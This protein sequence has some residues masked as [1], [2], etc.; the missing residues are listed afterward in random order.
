M[1]VNWFVL[2]R[3]VHRDLGY[4]ACALT[5]VY[6]ISGIAVNHV[7]DWNPNQSTTTE[8][9]ALGPLAAGSL[10]D[11]ER[12]VVQKARLLP[13][14]VKGRHRSGPD[15]LRV[16]L[17]NGGEVK[18]DLPTGKGTITRIQPRRG[19]FELNVLHLNHLKGVWT[20]V[21]DGYAVSLL[22]LG[23]SGLFMVSGK[24]GFFGRGKWFVLAG[25]VVPIVFV[26][27]YHAT[28]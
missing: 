27:V 11:L 26:W 16:F 3:A 28:R 7:A 6:A 12:Q 23:V 10:D 8:D 1:S 17:D 19:L 13:D 9:V 24:R 21:A 25:T 22:F 15:E 2:N 14:E 5:I 18:V 20:Y 4:F